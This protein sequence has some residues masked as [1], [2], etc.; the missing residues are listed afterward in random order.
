M[1]SVLSACGTPATLVPVPTNTPVPPTAV[2]PTLTPVPTFTPLPTTTP[3][4]TPTTSPKEQ[5]EHSPLVVVT[6]DELGELRIMNVVQWTYIDTAWESGN[7]KSWNAD[8][9]SAWLFV[10]VEIEMAASQAAQPLEIE[11]AE[12]VLTD[13]NGIAYELY[14]IGTQVTPEAGVYMWLY[15][16]PEGGDYKQ[17]GGYLFSGDTPSGHVFPGY[18]SIHHQLI[19]GGKSTID[20]LPPGGR[21]WIIDHFRMPDAPIL[22]VRAFSLAFEVPQNITEWNLRLSNFD[23]I[24]LPVPVPQKS[25]DGT[26]G[27][28]VSMTRD[29]QNKIWKEVGLDKF[30][31]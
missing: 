15:F 20:S 24:A 23:Q 7:V 1:A 12:V 6:D 3:F 14:N 18:R 31:P 2:P 22:P 4:S 21:G 25:S 27:M 29:E 16:D 11:S 28:T 30:V 8:Y 13:G 5:M 19:L 10:D 17:G 26:W 9:Q